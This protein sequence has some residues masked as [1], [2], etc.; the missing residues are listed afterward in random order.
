MLKIGELSKIS[1]V[2]VKT[3]RYYDEVG[4]LKPLEIDRF[5]G[6]RYYSFDQLP[7]LNRILALKDLGLTLE[8]IAQLLNEQ[9]TAEQLR[10][11]FRLKQVE[12]QQRMREE[13]ERLARVEARLKQIEM[14]DSMPEYDVVFKKVAPLTM[15][16]VRDIIPSYPE[17]GH[18]WDELVK[19]GLALGLGEP[20]PC[21][22]L[23]HSDEPEIDAEVCWPT[24]GPVTVH[25]RVQCRQLA[26]DEMAC[27]VHHGPFVTISEAYT[28]GLK[29]IQD[30]GYRCKGCIREVYLKPPAKPG[31][32]TDPNTVTEI[33]FPVEKI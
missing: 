21:F 16:S 9:L 23:Y 6:Y 33:Q 25:G 17:Q 22:T 7:R 4:L 3:L 13:G 27:V 20:M 19:Q 18:L 32:Q 8:Q 2:S 11:M 31:D 12:L 10:G 14:E 28:A 30:N 24:E 1:Q 29:W 15:I 26:G 5:T